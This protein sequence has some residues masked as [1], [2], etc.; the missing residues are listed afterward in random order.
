M[1][2]GYGNPKARAPQA[3]LDD[4]LDGNITWETA[5]RVYG[6]AIVGD[7]PTLDEAATHRL[8]GG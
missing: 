5:E 1:G 6:V 7:P 8:R 4:V 2:G 3:V